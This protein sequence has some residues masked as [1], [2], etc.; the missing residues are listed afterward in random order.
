MS[1]SVPTARAALL[2]VLPHARGGCDVVG[3]E[4][5]IRAQYTEANLYTERVQSKRWFMVVMAV[6]AALSVFIGREVFVR[7]IV[8]AAP[9]NFDEAAHSLPGFYILRDVRNLDL[10]AFYGDFHI[11]MLW[12]PMF[13]M[14]QAPFLAVLGRTDEAARLFATLM[15]IAGVFMS[16]IMAYQISPRLAPLA[17]L[18]SGLL[19]LSAPG[20]LFV[21]SWANQ[22]TPV[23]FVMWLV[24]I[25]FVQAM[26]TRQAVWFAATSIG[27][28]ALFLTKYNYAAFGLASIGLVDLISRVRV[29]RASETRERNLARHLAELVL[30]YAPF[31][32][33]LAYW[34]FGA[35]DTTWASAE[36]KW[37][38]FR[39]FVTNEDSGYVFWSEANLLFYVRSA[40][41]WL[42]P[43][44]LILA[45]SLIGAVYAVVRVR[46]PGVWLLAVFFGLSFILATAH[47]L[48]AD[49]Y[50][51][52]LFP[53]LWLLAGI[54]VSA[55]VERMSRDDRR[56]TTNDGQISVV[57]RLPSVVSVT[58]AFAIA[59]ASWL[60][61]LPRLQPV[62][63]GAS[64]DAVR[65]A[66]AQVVNWQDGNQ[67]VL[68]IGTFGELSPPLFEWRL[69]PLPVFAE[70]GNIQYDAPPGSGDDGGSDLEKVGAWLEQN[71]GAQVTL[72]QVAPESP[73]Y[74]T[75][76]MQKKN[77][78]RQTLVNEF[79]QHYASL[80]YQLADTKTLSQ[81]LTVSFYRPQS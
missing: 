10:K 16:A 57:R 81:G 28:F 77:L 5:C 29:W 56:Q 2:A 73:F 19:A 61:W 45:A 55:W 53:A 12:P 79:A 51:A 1:N 80:G 52:P 11:Q 35:N 22:E 72:I 42:M 41:N 68:I 49:R 34:F 21:G 70:R 59:V 67:P 65:A 32:L 47:Q 75:D 76:D 38:N 6:L 18:V 3:I 17:A 36:E 40:A 30:L 33:G 46:R 20:W 23:A 58:A 13:S 25:V 9:L 26:K 64:A 62:W 7:L 39:F 43:H 27:L 54:G 8:P 14:L 60:H 50:I 71:P 24:F 31:A 66:A 63:G 74:G 69:R 78:W 4:F 48:K 37:R 15:L 44:P